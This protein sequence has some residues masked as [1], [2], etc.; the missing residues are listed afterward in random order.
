MVLAQAKIRH[1]LIFT[2]DA[3]EPGY[4]Y[5][6]D[7]IRATFF[8]FNELQVGMM[9]ALDG[10]RTYEDIVNYIGE[11]F[12]VEVSPESVQRVVVR[13]EKELLLDV[14][15]YKVSS[16]KDRELV[17]KVLHKKG[18][19]WRTK[20]LGSS[21]ERRALSR[22]SQLFNQGV[23][24]IEH[25]DP[26]KASAYFTEVLT[27]NPNN[28]RARSILD[29][30]HEAFFMRHRVTP[31][32]MVMFHVWDPDAFLTRLDGAIGRFMFSGW[33]GV[34]LFTLMILSIHP[35]MDA[36]WPSS[37][38]FTWI[39]IVTYIPLSFVFTSLHELGH[40]LSC[41]HYG[42]RVNDM[43][44]LLIYGVWPG[45]YCDT[46][47]SYLFKE[48]RH[49]VIVSLAGMYVSVCCNMLALLVFHYT[50]DS[51]FLRKTLLI[52]LVLGFW[53]VFKNLIP[54]IALD[55]YYALADALDVR[56]LRE[57]SF[58][59]LGNLAK[60]I[61]L[62]IP[63]DDSD[64]TPRE[65]RIFFWYGA[66]ALIFTAVYIYGL[67][68][69]LLLPLAVK[70]LGTFGLVITI[71]YAFKILRSIIIAP[72]TIV[73][74]LIAKHRK[75]VFT[76]LR[77]AAFVAAGLAI[78][79]LLSMQ[80]SFYVDGEAIVQPKERYVARATEPGLLTEIHVREGQH[81]KAGDTIAVLRNDEL[82]LEHALLEQSLA[83]A[84]H[85]LSL[86]EAGARPEEI[87]LARAKAQAAEVATEYAMLDARRKASLSEE[88]L[89]SGST[90][91]S[92]M[93]DARASSAM[94][95]DASL[96]LAIVRAGSREE[97]IAA[98]RAEVGGL[99]ARL[100]DLER[101]E[102]QLRITSPIDGVVIGRKVED[103]LKRSLQVGD[104]ICEIHDLSGVRLEVML[105]AWEFSSGVGEGQLVN[106]RAVGSPNA[107]LEV[108][109]AGVR[110]ST[111]E[112]GAL[113]VDTTSLANPG[114]PTGLT[115]HA[116]IYGEPRSLAHRLFW[117]EILRLVQYE[118]WKLWGG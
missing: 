104:A 36:N 31:A 24:E 93:R 49:K 72:A 10:R 106:M 59:Y 67:W 113:I 51:F 88:K 27:I 4:Y 11:A 22:E 48:R 28:K 71:I 5:V 34:I 66:S 35:L 80:W 14:S 100:A 1:D 19:V 90:A 89:L 97:D 62:G 85:R 91:L 105:P 94:H 21:E 70:H 75:H 44:L 107:P 7:P 79:A 39:D 103:F 63:S 74:R 12:E 52:L 20:N 118:G 53:E 92:A 102:R 33:A 54:F 9:Q 60:R 84:R 30:I 45:A 87:A 57:R 32:Q 109:V 77:T 47:D 13:L 83:K 86:L 23:D 2:P 110:K 95:S 73:V 78:Y 26:C 3:A 112:D 116:R 82:L 25:G 16:A 17:R 114:W 108:S 69:S 42:G 117:T 76:P 61:L 8:R 98:A 15:S 96:S 50:A 18:L 99:E 29:A 68:I 38:A 40:G 58:Q 81:V 64:G 101:R 111:A 65:K 55:G 115:G 6:K 56:N 43:G 37:K 46:S 41:K